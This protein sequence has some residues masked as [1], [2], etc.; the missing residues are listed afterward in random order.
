MKVLALAKAGFA[1]AAAAAALLGAAGSAS[2]ATYAFSFADGANSAYESYYGDIVVSGQFTAAG[3]G[4]PITA[5]TGAVQIVTPGWGDAVVAG[6]ITGLSSYAG[7]DNILY[8]VGTEATYSL[9]G[10]SFEVAHNG[11]VADYKLYWWNNS[12]YLVTSLA[13]A[14]GNVW[15]GTNAGVVDGIPTASVTPV[16]EPAT[17]A[18]TILG[19]GL[20]GLALRAQIK[21]DRKLDTIRAEA[22]A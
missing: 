21:V 22:A 17:W 16:P 7:A 1:T 10:V 12:T 3:L 2:A 6:A 8:G 20:V 13:D 15:C 4:D 14:V 18:F 9:Q 11:Q 5:I 19:L